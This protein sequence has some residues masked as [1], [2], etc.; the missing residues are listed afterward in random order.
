[1][2]DT[3]W[4]TCG[5][6]AN[7]TSIFTQG[8]NR[9][10]DNESNATNTSATYAINTKI[11][12]YDHNLSDALRASNFDFGLPNC[13]IDGVRVKFP[14]KGY[15]NYG[16]NEEVG[17]KLVD[18]NGNAWGSQKK[19]AG[20]WPAALTTSYKGSSSDL[21]GTGGITRSQASDVDFGCYHRSDSYREYNSTPQ[22]QYFQMKI[23]YTAI[24]FTAGLVSPI[25]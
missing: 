14:R 16:G 5:T 21:W 2:A 12:G 24:A 10:W 15:Y 9:D 13:T 18:E 3:G 25:F 6:C 4:V 1:M 19:T 17:F 22:I 20:G 8:T 23:Y 7:N 11:D